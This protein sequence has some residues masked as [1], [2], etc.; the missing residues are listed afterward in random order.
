MSWGGYMLAMKINNTFDNNFRYDGSYWSTSSP[1]NESS[2]SSAGSADA[3]SRLYYEYQMTDRMRVSLNT[4]ANYIDETNGISGRTLKQCMTGSY[5]ASARSR[6][7]FLNWIDGA[8][9]AASNWGN[10]PNC[11]TRGFQVSVNQGNCRW[12]I[13]MNNEGD[14]NSNDASIGLGCHTNNYYGNRT[15]NAGGSRWSPDQAYHYNAW[16]WVK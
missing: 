15:T 3:V 16:V 2:F 14:C 5:T 10:Q 13:S 4:F 12:G 6:T 9:T 8:G 7:D 11:N 1:I